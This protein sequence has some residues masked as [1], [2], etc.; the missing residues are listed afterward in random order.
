MPSTNSSIDPLLQGYL[1]LPAVEKHIVDLLAVNHA[2]MSKELINRALP[3]PKGKVLDLELLIE[4]GLVTRHKAIGR[5][6]SYQCSIHLKDR[7]LRHLAK[8]PETFDAV[9]ERVQT[10]LPRDH[11]VRNVPNGSGA[12]VHQFL[13]DDIFVREVRIALY[14]G[15]MAYLLELENAWKEF[16]GYFHGG[17]WR[18]LSSPHAVLADALSNPFDVSVMD[19]LPPEIPPRV[20]IPM[21]RRMVHRLEFNRAQ[22]DFLCQWEKAFETSLPNLG[23]AGLLLGDSQVALDRVRADTHDPQIP[24]RM[25]LLGVLNLLSGDPDFGIQAFESALKTQRRLTGDK[26]ALVPGIYSA[27]H[28]FALLLRRTSK[29]L[30]RARGL[31]KLAEAEARSYPIYVL[32]GDFHAYEGSATSPRSFVETMCR[33]FLNALEYPFCDPWGILFGLTLL[34]RHD[35]HESA[36]ELLVPKLTSFAE[37]LYEN[38]L[39]WP[40]SEIEALAE[41]L[42][43]S[44]DNAQ[45]RWRDFK[46]QSGFTL[47]CERVRIEAPWER[48]LFAIENRFSG[49]NALRTGDAAQAGESPLRLAWYLDENYSGYGLEAREQ[50]RQGAGWSKGKKVGFKTLKQTAASRP[51]VTEQDLRIIEHISVDS[52][53]AEIQDPAWRALQGHPAF[54]DS[55]D[56][57]LELDFLTPEL[58]IVRTEGGRI[59][60][61]MWPQPG[62][63][64][65]LILSMDRPG[66]LVAVE[67]RQEHLRLHDIIGKGFEAPIEA[68]DALIDRL[69]AVSAL[70]TIASELEVN[71]PDGGHLVP[72]ASIPRVFATREGEGLYVQIQVRPFGDKGPSANPGEGP[73]TL[74]SLLEGQRLRTQR[75]HS[76]ELERAKSLVAAC[77]T[78]EDAVHPED[79]WRFEL[80]SAEDAYQALLE[81]TACPED[82][83]LIEWPKGEPI[84]MAGQGDSKRFSVRVGEQRDWFQVSG[85]LVLDHGEV[86]QMQTLLELTRDNQSR[87]ITLADDRILALTDTFRKRIEDLRA[88]SEKAGKQLKVHPLALPLIQ[89]MAD[90]FGSFE[91]DEAFQARIRALELSRH[92]EPELPSTLMAELRDYQLQGFRWLSRLA[93]WGVGACLADDM[94]LGKTLQAIAL[95][96]AR[97]PDGPTL[98]IAPTSVVFNWQ[99]EI[100][101][102]APTLRPLALTGDRDALVAGLGPYDVLIVSYGLLQQESVAELLAAKPFRTLVLDEAQ[103]IKNAMTRRS[104]SVMSLQGDFRLVM[105]GTPLENHLGELWNL[106]RFIN[107][108]LLGSEKSFNERFALPIERDRSKTARQR[109]KQLIQPFILRR[110]KSEVLTELPER[111]E[112]ELKVVLEPREAT[113]YEALRQKLSNELQT[114][115]EPMHGEHQG[116]RV[117]AAITQLRRA[118]CNPNLVAPDLGL[119]SSKMALLK[120]TLTELLDNRHKALVFSQFVDHLSL[121][122][123]ELDAMG[124][125]Y[126]YLDGQTPQNLRKK[127]VEAFQAGEG[128]VFLISLKAGGSGLN[129]TAADYVIHLDPWWNPA[130]EDQASSRAHRMGQERPVTVYRLVT[131]GTIEEQI[132]ALHKS[133][134][135]LAESLLEGGDMAGRLDTEALLRMIQLA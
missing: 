57:P 90:E 80:L 125:R 110:T 1:T 74:M 13:S 106:F 46:Q 32:L 87:F 29:D 19:A 5:P 78:L 121:V 77:P 126:Q 63:E 12:S 8:T 93:A 6:E 16:P 122:R 97:A 130:V 55:E 44:K 75:D 67:L 89:G 85:E 11:Y 84:V 114:A 100:T 38:G 53:G 70:V 9:I 118:C 91:A 96:L 128:E 95:M 64:E 24:E 81:L 124:I 133:K 3:L 17:Y 21:A 34:K 86:L 68:H 52:Y 47:L 113:F 33:S 83:H 10:V 54:F 23:F 129:L 2:P 48:V 43:A 20:L 36:M 98:V 22:Y 51:Y 37:S 105:T 42:G 103:A 132:V 104:Q 134:R 123:K 45:G 56:R 15:K 88:F 101:R 18:S 39:V 30:T 7:I 49:K 69:K 76:E 14:H 82:S 109:L 119:P 102:F 92:I 127:A 112:I 27:F 115:P 60:V 99:A 28:I 50:K 62:W 116:L 59:R 108:G 111:T 79:P 71:D 120:E 25:A 66:R 35:L 58:R 65:S 72:A 41:E 107:P 131:A 26:S 73:K 94:G 135:D 61:T 40:A 4:S 31:I 117:L